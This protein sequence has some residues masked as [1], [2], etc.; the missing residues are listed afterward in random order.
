MV[1]F[2]FF[3]A[4]RLPEA[5]PE[6]WVSAGPR[7]R[8]KKIKDEFYGEMCAESMR[9]K[10][11]TGRRNLPPTPHPAAVSGC[12]YWAQAVQHKNRLCPASAAASVE[13]PDGRDIRKQ[14][15]AID[16]ALQMLLF[17]ALARLKLKTNVSLMERE[18]ALKS[19]P[20]AGAAFRSR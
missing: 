14:S 9:L 15:M 17:L 2:S 1:E 16:P 7:R 12:V 11:N 8:K 19:D 3:S 5:R 4:T 20:S 13:R 6:P 10:R 18:T